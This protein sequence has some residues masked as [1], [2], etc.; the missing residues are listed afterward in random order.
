[1]RVTP[2]ET[3]H[4]GLVPDVDVPQASE[5][6]LS[7]FRS[8]RI[9]LHVALSQELPQ[10]PGT[11]ELHLAGEYSRIESALVRQ[12]GGIRVQEAAGIT[13]WL[14]RGNTDAKPFWS[15][16]PPMYSF[17]GSVTNTYG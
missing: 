17:E 13:Y 10:S 11:R 7:I 3:S 1:M 14:T 12:R 5:K 16:Q 6:F 2:L 9:P 4:C 15:P 8:P